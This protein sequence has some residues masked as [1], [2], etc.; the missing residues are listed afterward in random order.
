MDGSQLGVV[1]LKK[2]L[3]VAFER[4]LD[5][6]NVAPTAKWLKRKRKPERIRRLST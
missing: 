3:D 6:V 1:P 5:L 4:R 2:A